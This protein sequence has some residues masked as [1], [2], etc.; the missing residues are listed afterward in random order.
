VQRA[1]WLTGLL[2]LTAACDRS[3]QV[4]TTPPPSPKPPPVFASLDRT[5]QPP[6]IYG[7]A[8]SFVETDL[9]PNHSVTYRATGDAV[10]KYACGGAPQT[11]TTA[12]SSTAEFRSDGTGRAA[13]VMVLELAP[14][15]CPDGSRIRPQTFELSGVRVTDVEHGVSADLPGRIDGVFD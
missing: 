3:P 15:A 13:G 1:I 9:E 5:K 7:T 4:T 11:L 8:L 14:P 12:I 6:V 2:L 10:L